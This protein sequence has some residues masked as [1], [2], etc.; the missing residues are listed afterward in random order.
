M[1]WTDIAMIFER[2]ESMKRELEITTLSR[3]ACKF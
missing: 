1:N 3:Y 2:E